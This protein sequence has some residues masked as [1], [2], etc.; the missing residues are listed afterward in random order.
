MAMEIAYVFSFYKALAPYSV[1]VGFL[2]KMSP[3]GKWT[4]DSIFHSKNGPSIE[5]GPPYFFKY[6]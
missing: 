1:Y 5:Y 2:W 4:P 3:H 6:Y